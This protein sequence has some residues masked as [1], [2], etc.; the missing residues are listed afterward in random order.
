MNNPE[1]YDTLANLNHPTKV[2]KLLATKPPDFAQY[3]D[4]IKKIIF[5]NI[6]EVQLTLKL[7]QA[8]RITDLPHHRANYLVAMQM[9]ESPLASDSDSTIS[10]LN[11]PGIPGIESSVTTPPAFGLLLA[12]FHNGDP[13]A[14]YL[15]PGIMLQIQV[16]GMTGKY[17]ENGEKQSD[18]LNRVAIAHPELSHDHNNN[19]EVWTLT[20]GSI[21]IIHRTE[22][23]EKS[24]PLRIATYLEI[25]Y[26]TL[27][28]Q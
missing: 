15:T 11:Q 13:M 12:E 1:I 20:Q 14:Q 5:D 8:G 26:D 23:D 2:D 19:A 6:T 7:I 28:S 18:F 4:G 3:A 27:T 9:K 10:Q 17:P 22:K 24:R 16:A 25:P 21:K